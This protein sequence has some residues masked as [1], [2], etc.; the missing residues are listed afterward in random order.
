VKTEEEDEEVVFEKRALLYNFAEAML[1]KGK[2]IK[3]WLEKGKGDVKLLKH[4]EN[5][6]IRILMRQEKTLKI[7]ENIKYRLEFMKQN[8][9]DFLNH[10]IALFDNK[11]VKER[12]KFPVSK[13]PFVIVNDPPNVVAKPSAH[14]QS[15]PLTVTA[16]ASATPFVVNV[17]PV[18]DPVSVI[19]PV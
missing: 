19:A 2:G 16:D 12:L 7:I 6:R 10:D 4:K 18:A 11:F 14:P 15:T 5:D 9:N 13:D 17:L 8:D 1:D 3:S